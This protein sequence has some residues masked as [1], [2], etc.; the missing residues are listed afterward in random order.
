MKMNFARKDR[1]RIRL[2]TRRG[3]NWTGKNPRISDSLLSLRVQSI[4]VDREG[5]DRDA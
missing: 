4:S 5:P 1:D 2:Y 3:Y